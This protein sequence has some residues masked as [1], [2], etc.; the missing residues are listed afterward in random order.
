MTK[1]SQKPVTLLF[2]IGLGIFV[3]FPTKP[4]QAQINIQHSVDTV[5]A[6]MAGT[7]TPQQSQEYLRLAMLGVGGLG[8]SDFD[9]PI[10]LMINRQVLQQCPKAYLSFYQRIQVRNPYPPGSLINPK[11]TQLIEQPTQL[12][13]PSPSQTPVSGLTTQQ[14]SSKQRIQQKMA[15]YDE[16]VSLSPMNVRAYLKRGYAR[17]EQQDYQGAIDDYSEIIRL[18]PNNPIGYANRGR[19]R[20]KMG[21]K[22]GA[23]SDLQVAL[24]M[25]QA[26]GDEN[27][28]QKVLSW[29]DEA[30]QMP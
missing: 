11:P 1:I 29:L 3:I 27:T 17:F 15:Q 8:I 26:Q 13:H 12:I 28:Y 10:A 23:I 14:S 2:F 24:Q 21:N 16:A 22:Q 7:Q 19:S 4:I 5:C 18:D 25:L 20:E 9:N 30:Q 6:V